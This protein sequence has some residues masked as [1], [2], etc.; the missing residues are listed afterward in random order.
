MHQLDLE[1]P[2]AIHKLNDCISHWNR[3][4]AWLVTDDMRI[5]TEKADILSFKRN[6]VTENIIFWLGTEIYFLASLKN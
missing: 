1:T 6:T 4:C 2:N 3:C 5:Q